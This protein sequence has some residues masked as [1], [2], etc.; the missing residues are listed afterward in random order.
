[1]NGSRITLSGNQY[2]IGNGIDITDRVEAEQENTILLQEIHHRVKNNLAIISGILRLELD[3]VSDESYNRLPLERSINRIHSI[4]KVHE[5]LYQTSSFSRVSVNKYISELITTITDTIQGK[6][7]ISIDIDVAEI[8]MNINEIIPLGM[9][10][11]ELL[12][13]S[14]KYAFERKKDGRI[15]VTVALND[16]NAYE[17]YYSDNGKGFDR[18]AFE[19][20]ETLG[21]TIV[22]MLL[23]QL[24]AEYE[25]NT[26]DGFSISFTF[27][28]KETGSH[29]NM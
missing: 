6:D 18:S 22:N 17:V 19:N 26:E 1:M 14:L 5:L 2:V 12:T 9:L 28:K 24:E 27:S 20:S 7:Q 11:N 16:D 13:N 21:L 4:A 3:D 29:S 23:K 25:V 8:E 10:L 15:N